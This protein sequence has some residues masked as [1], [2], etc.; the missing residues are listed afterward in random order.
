MNKYTIGVFDSGIGGLS[1]ANA[2]KKEFPDY[3]IEY[4]QDSKNLPYGSKTASQIHGFIKPIFDE[5]NSKCDVI[6]IACNTV[7]TT[8]ITKLRKEYSTPIIGI[9]PMIK[10]ACQLSNNRIVTVCATPTTLKSER[11]KELKEKYAKNITIF[12]P[13]C[14]DWSSLIEKNKITADKIKDDIVPFLENGSDVI[15]LGCT[16]YHWVEEE[17]N[18]IVSNKAIVLQPEQAIISRLKEVL[19]IIDKNNIIV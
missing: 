11:Y 19:K 10:P 8:L 17:I 12:E 3:V 9:E 6:V 5:L 13:D 18:K 1:V 7:T 14:S 16:H 4:R 15:V 2:I